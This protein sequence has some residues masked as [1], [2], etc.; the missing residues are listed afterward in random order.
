[1][2]MASRKLSIQQTEWW[3]FLSINTE[4]ISL[5]LEIWGY[6]C[7]WD[8]TGSN[9]CI[10][11]T[12]WR[13]VNRFESRVKP[14][15]TKPWRNRIT[16]HTERSPKVDHGHPPQTAP[17][18]RRAFF[19]TSLMISFGWFYCASKSLYLFLSTSLKELRSENR[20]SEK[21]YLAW[22]GLPYFSLQGIMW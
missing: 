8:S 4:S 18:C 13:I 2:E 6:E 7:C 9:F 1:M 15:R 10:K 3:L 17:L 11:P 21:K 16:V 14:A 19:L 20:R 12:C 5:E 22:L